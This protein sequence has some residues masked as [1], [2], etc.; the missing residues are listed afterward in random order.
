MTTR[1]KVLRSFERAASITPQGDGDQG[2]GLVKARNAVEESK[3]VW[4]Q[5]LA[6]LKWPGH[7]AEFEGPGK[8]D[9][10]AKD[11]IPLAF[12]DKQGWPAMGT[13][14]ILNMRTNGYDFHVGL[15]AGDESW[16]D[17]RVKTV[18]ETWKRSFCFHFLLK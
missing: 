11:I 4:K 13:F 15:M 3:K 17:P 7:N 5:S 18:F 14:D 12:A 10:L 6:D 16:T 9:A 2:A 1:L 8:P